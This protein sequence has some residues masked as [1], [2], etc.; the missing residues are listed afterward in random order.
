MT[1]FVFRS[2][3]AIEAPTIEDAYVLMGQTFDTDCEWVE[4]AP[5]VEVFSPDPE[6]ED[7]QE[8]EPAAVCICWPGL[9]ER[10][11]WRSSCPEHGTG[12]PS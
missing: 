12:V 2:A 7:V 1:R 10:G 11:G 6:P 3:V 4:L 9:V 5:N 8:D